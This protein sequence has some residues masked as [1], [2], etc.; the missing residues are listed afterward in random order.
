MK[1]LILLFAVL[2]VGCQ[3]NDLTA[4]PQENG[5]ETE[6]WIAAGQSN[7][8]DS[9][10]YGDDVVLKFAEGLREATGRDVIPLNVGIGGTKIN[11]WVPGSP[12]FASRIEPLAALNLNLK[13]VIWWQGESDVFENTGY[14]TYRD[15]LIRTVDGFRAAFGVWDLPFYIV[16]IQQLGSPDTDQAKLIRAAQLEAIEAL[17]NIFLIESTDVTGE[18]V[19]IDGTIIEGQTHPGYVYPIIAERLV[20]QALDA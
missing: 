14:D 16:E 7:I 4:T 8:S 2:F 9:F 20:N 12:C 6:I 5:A 3:G 17:G 10:L 19:L 11:C 18:R 15:N 1:R 13:G